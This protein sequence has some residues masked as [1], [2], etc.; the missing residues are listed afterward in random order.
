MTDLDA[1]RQRLFAHGNRYENQSDTRAFGRGVD[2]ALAA[3]EQAPNIW[4][5]DTGLY[6][7]K[8]EEAET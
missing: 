4:H 2:A 6:R 8:P 5:T 3:L 1:L 7:I